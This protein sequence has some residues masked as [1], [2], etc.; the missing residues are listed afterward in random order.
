[1][2][3]KSK[4]VAADSSFCI[5]MI[6]LRRGCSFEVG[7]CENAG[8]DQGQ[9]KLGSINYQLHKKKNLSHD[10]IEPRNTYIYIYIT[11]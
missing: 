5:Y 9:N 1:M 10:W 6:F 2:V 3:Y 11:I 8:P 4:V 7:G